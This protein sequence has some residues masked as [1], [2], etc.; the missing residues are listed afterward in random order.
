MDYG[1]KDYSLRPQ[2][3]DPLALW[4]EG[5]LLYICCGGSWARGRSICSQRAIFP[6]T[7][8]DAGERRDADGRRPFEATSRGTSES[9]KL[10]TTRQTWRRSLWQS[11]ACSA[12]PVLDLWEGWRLCCCA[13]DTVAAFSRWLVLLLQLS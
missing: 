2:I 4:S 10:E 5:V 6:S 8:A 7:V 11:G 1:P 3:S 12:S 9:S 13:S